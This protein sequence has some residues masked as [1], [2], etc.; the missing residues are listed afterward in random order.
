VTA[1]TAQPEG[2]VLADARG[3]RDW[4]GA[5][6]LTNIPQAQTLV[7]ASLRSLNAAQFAPL[8]RLKCLELVRE[9]VA[10]LQGEQRARYFGKTLPLSPNDSAAWSTG[11]ALLAEMEEGYRR[12]LAEASGEL[13]PHRALVMHRIV[14]YLGARM[15]FHAIVYRRFDPALWE[16]LHRQYAEAE[17]EGI[18]AERVKDSLEGEQDATSSVADAY[19]QVVLLQA[20]YLAEMTGPQIDFAE[21]LARH[22]LRKARVVPAA[23]AAAGDVLP[24]VVDLS[25]SIGAR[26]LA[27]AQLGPSHRVLDVEAISASLRKRIH[28]LQSDEDATRLG[29]P[30]QAAG[31]D[32]AAQL[33]RLHKLWCEGAPP[34]P[35][36]KA[37][38][39]KAAGIVFTLPEIHF[40]VGGGKLFEQPGKRRE[41]TRE[42]KQDIE[43]FGRVS[44]RTYSRM[45]AE[46][47]FSVE[48][49]A[50]IDEMPGTW[51]V[52]RPQTASKGVAI[53]RLAGVRLGE[54]GGFF[55][56][57]VR[58]LV[59]ETDGKIVATVALY[60]GK[61]EPIAVRAG[62]ARN[63]TSAQW[64]QGFRLPALE[65]LQVP[66]SLVVPVSLA[67]RGRGIEVWEGA[68]KEAT[69]Y[70]VLE[71]GADFDRVSTF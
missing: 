57:V 15:L 35:P 71:R 44:E 11:A 68:P 26:P 48:P 32:L 61:P 18:A 45:M 37:S 25:S 66:A 39:I 52:Q 53:G 29:L 31:L 30:P 60:P 55:L 33:K 23:D 21:A 62:D 47:N 70:E 13:A 34:R 16:R 8:E 5:L 54:A 9:K 27:R 1:P 42:E 22:W 20:A 69:V 59:Q 49:W 4:L 50:V 17:S 28:A 12:A 67:M 63:R 10:F 14:R 64:M 19:Q 3:C 56:G 2:A 58:A 41:L 43:V 36:G 7:L 65:R 24:L 46:H 40:F 6:P 38:E 51:R